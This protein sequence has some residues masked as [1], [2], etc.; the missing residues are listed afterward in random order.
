M[1]K[2]RKVSAFRCCLCP[3]PERPT[4][5]NLLDFKLLRCQSCKLISYCGPQHQKD[6][7]PEH[8]DFCR[9]ITSARKE[10]KLNHILDINGNV[11]ELSAAQLRE[12]K[13]MIQTLVI[14]KLN[15]DLTLG[16]RE[17]IWF[18]RICNVCN[19]HEGP[20]IPCPNCFAIGY[21]SEEHRVEDI[22]EHLRVC[23]EL[24]LCYNFALE[25]LPDDDVKHIPSSMVDANFPKDLFEMHRLSTAFLNKDRTDDFLGIR[26]PNTS[27][28]Y[29]KFA[30]VCNL[31]NVATVL[32]GL[33][34]VQD[35]KPLVSSI[36]TIHIVGANTE[37]AL[38]TRYE[39]WLLFYWLP[40]I[41]YINLIFIGPELPVENGFTEISYASTRKK[42]VKVVY[43]KMKYEEFI[44]L[45]SE[46]Q[47]TPDLI[48]CLNC[49]FAEHASES[50]NSWSEAIAVMLRFKDI[51]M[52][53]T[54]Y[55]KTEAT[56]NMKVLR[57]IADGGKNE[58]EI[59]CDGD[60]NLFRDHRPFRNFIGYKTDVI[61]YYNGYLS[62]ILTGK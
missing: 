27:S 51:P 45:A 3:N 5:E 57:E 31:S 52:M 2:N 39:C 55:V 34:I 49:G 1:S 54:S 21:C 24:H 46:N 37:I 25:S 43:K 12:V 59:I 20:L 40:T 17:L 6:H 15:R 16:E 56:S 28:E 8:K 14:I 19:S 29:Q 23:S 11:T 7:W 48:V 60:L 35:Y 62:V 30:N 36:L 42:V 33:N 41:F 47:K 53:F 58:F 61:Y 13:F 9:A 4:T 18:P 44:P 22:V 38:F 50:N 32:H 10:W 26:Q